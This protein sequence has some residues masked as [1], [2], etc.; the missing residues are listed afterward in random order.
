MEAILH[1]EDTRDGVVFC[2]DAVDYGPEPVECVRWLARNAN[3][4]VRGNHDN[5]L[6]FDQDCQCLGTF[7]EFSLATRAWHR[8]L[9]GRSELGFLRAMPTLCRFRWENRRFLVAHATPQGDMFEYLS[10][11]QWGERVGDLD[12]DFVLLG[13]THVQGLQTFGKVTVVNPGSVGLARDYRGRACY[14]VYED[15]RMELKRI[16]YDGGRTAA[17]LRLA[18]LPVPVFEGLVKV[19]GSH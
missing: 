9:L 15:G 13:H 14:A 2:G 1:K 5:A 8:T 12:T 3:H 18:P 7:R 17:A 19:L 4:V 10:P 11:E 16:R 6:A